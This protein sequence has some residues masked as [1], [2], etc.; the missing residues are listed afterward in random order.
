LPSQV[1]FGE[2]LQATNL[3]MPVIDL[4]AA[5]AGAQTSE[6]LQNAL[7]FGNQ[8]AFLAQNNTQTVA[9]TA[10]FYRVVGAVTGMNNS[11]AYEG[12]YFS[13]TDGL[14][15]K[16]VW[17]MLSF[18]TSATGANG[19]ISESFDLVFFLRGGDSLT[20]TATAVGNMQ[21]SSRQIA[22]V[23]GNLTNPVGFTPQ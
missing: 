6:L 20:C 4:T 12:G 19:M 1:G 22:D 11:A 7:S 8:T 21:G 9:N 14:S 23:N 2:D 17:A 18:P 16:I 15:S 5:A 13:I 3:I 10:G